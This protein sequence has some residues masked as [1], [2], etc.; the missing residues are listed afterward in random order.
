MKYKLVALT[1]VLL[2]LVTAGCSSGSSSGGGKLQIALSNSFIGNQW[3]VEMENVFKAACAMPPYEDPGRLQRLQRRQRRLHPVAA[4]L[5]PDLQGV[6]AIVINA[7][8]TSGLNGV[9]QQACDRGIVVVRST[10]RR[11]TVRPDGQHRPGQ[12][13]KQLAQFS[14]T[15]QGPGQR[16]H[17]HRRGRHRR[18]QRPQQGRRRGVRRQPGHQWSPSTAA[19]WDSATAQRDTAAQLPSLPKVD[20]VWVSGRHRRRHQGFCRRRPVAAVDR[21]RGGERLPQVHGRAATTVPR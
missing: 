1:A 19:M 13:G 14:S 18:R 16:R 5:Q 11:R 10:T 4:D 8:S 9:V 21:R 17:G 2:L 7:A 6:D 3:R 15:A 12:F 20:G